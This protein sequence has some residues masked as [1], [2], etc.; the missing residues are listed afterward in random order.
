MSITHI[1]VY[2][3]DMDCTYYVMAFCLPE[4]VG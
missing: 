2:Y 1:G 4:G 3:F